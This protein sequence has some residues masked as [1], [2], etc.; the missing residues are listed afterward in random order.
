M[1]LLKFGASWCASCKSLSQVLET[2]D[3]S[4]VTVVQDI[5]ID[6]NVE[7]T[8]QYAIKSVPTMILIKDEA[9]VS[10]MTGTAGPARVRQFIDG[11]K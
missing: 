7:L 8:K 10:R 3:I 6:K 5:D 11:I 1:K 2:M 9:E 4:P